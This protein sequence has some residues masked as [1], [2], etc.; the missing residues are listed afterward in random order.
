MTLRNKICFTPAANCCL[1]LVIAASMVVSI[2]PVQAGNGGTISLPINRPGQKAKSGLSVNISNHWVEGNGYRPVQIE[3]IPNVAAPADRTITVTLTPGNWMRG[4]RSLRAKCNVEIPEGSTKVTKTLS[5]PQFDVWTNVEIEIFEDGRK[6]EELSVN[7]SFPQMQNHWEWTEAYPSMLFIDADAP[8]INE[9]RRLSRRSTNSASNNLRTLPNIQRCARLFPPHGDFEQDLIKNLES[10]QNMETEAPTDTEILDVFQNLSTAELRQPAELPTQW[11]NYTCFDLIYISLDDLKEMISEYP[12]QWDAMRNYITTGSTLIVC[13]IGMAFQELNQL[14]SLLRMRSASTD[15]GDAYPGW[16]VPNP[17]NYGKIPGQFMQDRVVTWSPSGQPTYEQIEVEG[18]GPKSIR[19]AAEVPD[20]LF[21]LRPLGLGHVAAMGS[22]D[23]FAEDIRQWDWLVNEM[24]AERWQWFLRHGFSRMR[25][26]SHFWEFLIPGVGAAPISAFLF[27][28]T[29]FV[30]VIGPVN[31]FWLRRLNRL[32]LLLITVPVGAAIVT[33]CLLIY[34]LVG[35]GFATRVRVRSFTEINSQDGTAAS[36]SRQSYYAG[37]A[38]SEGMVYPARAAVYPIDYFPPK[39]NQRR[40][41]LYWGRYQHLQ[42]G[43]LKS[44]APCQTMVVHV[45]DTDKQVVIQQNGGSLAA[46]NRLGT[47]IDKLL[48]IDNDKFYW[49]TSIRNGQTC[50]LAELPF[51]DVK[52]RMQKVLF[53]HQPKIPKGFVEPRVRR[54]Y[55]GNMD[56]GFPK[57]TSASSVL[58]R[59]IAQLR[60]LPRSNGRVYFAITEEAPETVPLG[61]AGAVQQAGLNVTKGY[62]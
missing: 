53:M 41:E 54:Y 3:V 18:D 47:P 28:I 39:D 36:W 55:G 27:I 14:E 49:S 50:K 26:N 15:T 62:W 46:V 22:E 13:G 20:T 4:Q 29:A 43:Y 5:V 24:Q 19:P 30:V 17:S 48:V 38:P 16:T 23:P 10:G 37:L 6:W 59:N 2:R 56:S 8:P 58:E 1:V 31:Y 33:A 61:V 40:H 51:E 34:A 25:K 60:L 44:R 21:L 7:T 57:P 12:E 35:D 32:Y 9:Q 45:D 42:S 11:I 52:D